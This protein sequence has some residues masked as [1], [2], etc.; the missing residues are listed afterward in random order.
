MENDNSL[1]TAQ[2]LARS[3]RTQRLSAYKAGRAVRAKVAAD[4]I[5]LAI[6]LRKARLP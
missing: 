5:E 1:T 4:K 2:M 6:K 3:R